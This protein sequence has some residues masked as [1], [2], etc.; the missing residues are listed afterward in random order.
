[1]T[2]PGVLQQQSTSTWHMVKE[3]TIT[4]PAGTACCGLQAHNQVAWGP[5]EHV[6]VVGNSMMEGSTTPCGTF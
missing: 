4:R 5:C 2:T 3:T 6:L 1:M